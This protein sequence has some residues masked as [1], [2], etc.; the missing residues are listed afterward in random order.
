MLKIA[1]LVRLSDQF[2]NK[3]IYRLKEYFRYQLIFIDFRLFRM[4]LPF[5]LPWG[6]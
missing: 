3:G 6:F 5:Q 2:R 1:I 4:A